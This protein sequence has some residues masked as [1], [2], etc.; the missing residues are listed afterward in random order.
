MATRSSARIFKLKWAKYTQTYETLRHLVCQI[1]NKDIS[2]CLDVELRNIDILCNYILKNKESIKEGIRFTHNERCYDNLM[3]IIP[4][5]FRNLL[6]QLETEVL[7]VKD[8][9]I[10]RVSKQMNKVIEYCESY[11]SLKIT[12]LRENSILCDDLIRY[13][14][15]FM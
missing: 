10:K 15:E 2:Y 14:Q 7:S 5:V 9:I 8:S 1:N 3:R 6:L 13:V 11:L 12:V 4:R